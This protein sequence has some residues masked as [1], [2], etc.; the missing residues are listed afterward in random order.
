MS[1]LSWRMRGLGVAF[2][3]VGSLGLVA[4]AEAGAQRRIVDPPYGEGLPNLGWSGVIDFNI[5]DS[6]LATV[7]TGWID[8]YG[9]K[10]TDAC[11]NKLSITQA[12][13]T[14]YD[15]DDSGAP[16]PLRDVTLSYGSKVFRDFNLPLALR[17]YVVDDQIKA[18]QGGFLFPEF[19][20]ASDAPFSVASDYQY[21]A[22]WLNFNANNT[23][24][25]GLTSDEPPS[26]GYAFLTNCSFN[27]LGNGPAGAEKASD[28]QHSHPD[29][30]CSQNGFGPENQ[31]ILRPIP[32][33]EVY[34]MGLASFGVLGV[35]ARRRR[36]VD[37]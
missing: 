12:T 32:E 16:G 22:F 21:S 34:L 1:D 2:V 37:R 27:G 10:S 14:L 6:C 35:W 4:T 20:K 13:L 5:A 26:D 8:N 18:V 17:M 9:E 25:F 24:N 30:V 19:T 31:A 3:V 11:R 28:Y 29:A 23:N 33:P 7:N 15:I 36:R